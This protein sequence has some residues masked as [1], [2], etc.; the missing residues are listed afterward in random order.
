MI[1]N[2]QNFVYQLG[3]LFLFK[4]NY[5]YL[6]R[7]YY[8]I[9]NDQWKSVDENILLQQERLFNLIKYAIK[10]I[11]YYRNIAKSRNITISRESIFEDI[12]QFPI[13]TKDIIRENRND[14]HSDLNRYDYIVNTS[15]GTTGEP[16]KILQDKTYKARS[17]ASN[18]LFDEF[19]NYHLGDKL[20]R[21]W[22]D[23]SEIINMSKGVFKDIK[24]KVLKNTIFQNSFKLSEDLIRKYIVEI[25]REKPKIIIAY[26][27]SIY[28]LAKYIRRKNLHVHSINSIITSA[29]VLTEKMR[30]FIEETFQSQV[31]N[32]Y[33]SRE[34]GIIAMSCENSNL[35]HLN[36]HQQYVEILDKD[37]KRLEEG[38]K[39]NIIITNLHNYLMPLIR[40]KIGDIGALNYSKCKCGRGT[41]RL[42]N[43]Y[44][45]VVDVFKNSK[46]DLIDGEYFTHLFYFR[47]GIKKFQVIQNEIEHIVIKIVPQDDQKINKDFEDDIINKIKIVMGKDCKIGFQYVSD[48][49]PPSSGKFRYTISNVSK[50]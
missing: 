50:N 26:V 21:L 16:I 9:K 14:L 35:L 24:N 29:G 7:E 40:Y 25:N 48:I 20:I 11:P 42:E 28:E 45:R 8:K 49:P 10:F 27:Q 18:I 43:V 31:F 39:G 36:M 30:N 22:G 46:G 17:E 41:I 19:G 6:K 15:G 33:G 1:V 12:L 34:V 37:N 38:R 44:G 47:E 13:L 32:R 2:I 3:Y 5:R 23:E 4:D